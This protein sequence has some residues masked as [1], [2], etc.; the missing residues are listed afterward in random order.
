MLPK[1]AWGSKSVI[2]AMSA[3][4]PL[5][6]QERTSVRDLGMSRMCQQ[7]RNAPQQTLP[8]QL[9]SSR[10]SSLKKRQ[11]VPWVMILVGVD[12]IMPDSCNRSE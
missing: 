11:S 9:F 1:T 12:L 7:R 4:R 6:P 5:L 3:A 8:A 10:L 2:A